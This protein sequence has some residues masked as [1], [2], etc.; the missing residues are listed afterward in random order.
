[1]FLTTCSFLPHYILNLLVLFTPRVF[2]FVNH[3]GRA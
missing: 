3:E 1:M 2:D